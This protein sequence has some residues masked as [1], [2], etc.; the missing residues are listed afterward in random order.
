MLAAES[1]HVG[2]ACT[3]DG[4]GFAAQEGGPGKVA[5]QGTNFVTAHNAHGA[6]KPQ[7]SPKPPYAFA[8]D[9]YLTT[10]AIKSKAG[11]LRVRF[12]SGGLMAAEPMA[13]E[14]ISGSR[15]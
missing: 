5:E 4:K 13:L 8:N 9:A 12:G 10:L 7:G 3:G 6:S 15:N 2:I 1:G 11:E 14:D